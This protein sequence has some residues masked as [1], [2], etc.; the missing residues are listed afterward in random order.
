MKSM[1][2]VSALTLALGMVNHVAMADVFIS[3]YL[4][5]A[6]YNKA[7]ELYNNGSNDV[8]LSEYRIA[9]YSNGNTTPT[10][11][12]LE[13]TLAAGTT[14]V[15]AHGSAADAIQAIASMTNS[16]IN[17]N[18][19]DAVVLLHNDEVIDSIGKVGEDPGASWPSDAN[20]D[21]S[22]VTTKDH[23]LRR[24]DYPDTDTGDE[25]I[26]SLQWQAYSRDDFTDLGAYQGSGDDP[27][28]PDDDVTLA[29]DDPV[30]SVGSVQ[31]TGNATPVIGQ[32][33]AISGVITGIYPGLT[34]FYVQDQGDNDPQSSDGIFV[35]GGQQDLT[36]LSS[37]E[38]V[39]VSG[40][41]NEYYDNTQLINATWVSCGTSAL[42]QPTVLTLPVSDLNEFERLEGMLVS[43]RDLTVSDVYN[44]DRYGEISLSSGLRMTPTQIAESG[45]DAQAVVAANALNELV[46]DD[47]QSSN[48]PAGQ[49]LPYLDVT[50]PLRV[51]DVLTS[52]VTGPL[53][54]SFNKY[55]IA[56][57]SLDSLHFSHTD[58]PGDAPLLAAEGNLRI[59]SFNVLN[60]FNGDG[61]QGG[62]PTSRG[63]E[64]Y[65]D[66]LR[67]QAKLLQALKA[68][69]ADVIGLLEIE[70]D[71]YGELSAINQLT[72]Q[73]NN[74][75]AGQRRYAFVTPDSDTLGTDRVTSAII[76]DKKVLSVTDAA[77]YL[78]KN[79]SATDENGIPLFNSDVMRPSLGQSF[80]VNKDHSQFTLIM[81]HLRSKSGSC[82]AGDDDTSNGGAGACNG[83]RTR[84]AEAIA[85]W[86]AT[87][88]DN[89]LPI[90]LMGDFNSYAMEDPILTLADAGY[91]RAD[92]VL[93]QDHS[94][95]YIYQGLVGQLDHALMNTVM[96][97]SLVALTEWHINSGLPPVL[98]YDHCSDELD[99]YGNEVCQENFYRASDHD[100]VVMEV[101]LDNGAAMG[102]GFIALFGLLAGLR[103]R[104]MR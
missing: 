3:E 74:A 28:P 67:Q 41:A 14:F 65:Q 21:G 6:S 42:P 36:A 81:N 89:Q 25:F 31:G 17:F 97:Q 4:E 33:V 77:E 26:P 102:A 2:T 29:C 95:S 75:M 10:T 86:T 9:R 101:Q 68:M 12:A 59:A 34:G 90:V 46:L 44:L 57:A 48:I 84:A 30:V 19:N 55:R 88:F 54:Y 61:Q 7:L 37:G 85:Q 38:Q 52:T 22:D 39:V 50:D 35:Y 69:D 80:Q 23:D 45:A 91:Q 20:D 13:G 24:T 103:R 93:G 63:A 78:D 62:F 43:I 32:R 87:T 66:F 92:T 47:G 18:G 98:Q 8:D 83:T 96:Q 27:T 94:Y 64:T 73:L 49:P 60:Y 40:T 82:G 79:N 11:I 51:G 16:Q 100:P 70:N 104:Y 99:Q 72:Q 76:Y 58:V 15:I 1:M 71:G 56:P 5:G 53:F